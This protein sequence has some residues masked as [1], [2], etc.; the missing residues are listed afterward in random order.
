MFKVDPRKFVGPIMAIALFGFAIRLLVQEASKISKD[1]FLQG[2]TSVE[3]AYLLIAAFLIALNYGLLT[4]YDL[5]ALRY[6]CKALPLRRIALV[7]FLGYSLGNNLGTLIAAAPIRYRFYHR[8]G[9]SH[10]QI[11]ALMS[12]LALTFWSGV[13]V[14]GGVVL[15]LAPIKLPADYQLP[16]GT[17][18]L[19]YALLAIAICYAVVCTFWHKPWPIGKLRLR[20][21][22]LG[23]ACVQASVAAVDLLISATALYLVMPGNADVP[24]STV[25]AAYLVGIVVSLI[26]Q[27]PGGLGVLELILWT[28]LKDTVGKPVLASVLIFRVLYYILPLMFG[29]VV[30]VAHEIYSGAVE[31]KEDAKLEAHSVKPTPTIAGDPDTPDPPF[32]DAS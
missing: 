3:P 18:T 30:L 22:A 4:C 8:W 24:F 16:F 23:L 5:L 20:P 31:A 32:I 13:C 27:V 2:L 11:V 14:L 1:E 7:A 28:L 25:L 12:V 10:G 15:T 21:P 26:T 9:L 6:V 17:R 29:M 19:G